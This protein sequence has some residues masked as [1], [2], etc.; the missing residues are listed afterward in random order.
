MA[1]VTSTIQKFYEVAQE[2]DFSRDCFFRILSISFG[3]GSKVTFDEN[4]LVYAKGGQLPG[5]TITNQQVSFMGLQ[6][7]ISGTVKYDGSE[8]YNIKFFADEKSILRD[9][10]EAASREVF[11]DQTSTGNYHIAKASAVIDLVQLDP[12][13]NVVKHYQL[14]GAAVRKINSIEYNYSGD[15]KPVEID[16]TISYHYYNIIK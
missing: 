1:D 13:F 10:L 16:C 4:D 2:R 8:A 5:R 3:D 15:G 14:V 6:F 11:D 7:N 9:K 12:E